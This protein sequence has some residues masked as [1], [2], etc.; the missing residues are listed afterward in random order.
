MLDWYQ[1]LYIGEGMKKKAQK[2]MTR[3]EKGKAAPG[4]YL[5]TLSAH[6]DNV[7]EIISAMYLMQ[8]PLRR[9]C[10]KIVGIAWSYEEALELMQQILQDT[11]EN[12][13]TFRVEKWIQ[14]R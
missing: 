6:P 12:T 9:R 5:L 14:D 7:L 8:E 3:I 10:P 11:Y 13:G 1:N 4:V 2:A